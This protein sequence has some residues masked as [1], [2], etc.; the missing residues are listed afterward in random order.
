MVLRT[1][2]IIQVVQWETGRYYTRR[3]KRSAEQ[4]ILYIFCR[5]SL[6]YIIAVKN[7]SC[8]L[9]VV[10]VTRAAQRTN[11]T[12]MKGS[13]PLIDADGSTVASTRLKRLGEP[14]EEL[15]RI[16][17]R[18]RPT[19]ILDSDDAG[20]HDDVR[21]D[22][23]G[24]ADMHTEP[25]PQPLPTI[26]VPPQSSK[27]TGRHPRAL[28]EGRVVDTGSPDQG[29]FD[30]ESSSKRHAVLSN[31]LDQNWGD[32]IIPNNWPEENVVFT[33][34]MLWDK[35]DPG[36]L[37]LRQKLS[38]PKLKKT[39]AVLRITDPRH[40]CK[41]E[42]GVF[43][44]EAISQNVK[45]LNYAGR[46]R[47]MKKDSVGDGNRFLFKLAEQG[48]WVVDID[49]SIVGNESRFAGIFSITT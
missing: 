1:V 48:D 33:D 39:I 20:V 13:V 18:T 26:L 23:C 45:I 37:G 15:H 46:V 32:Q 21:D 8:T 40:P 49:A 6:G 14:D 10:I 28:F 17:K 7:H 24:T 4:V 44:T 35:V 25:S 12:R 31:V 41:G 11:S 22:L 43:S 42:W 27:A 34:L 29:E 3:G 5:T 36:A 38:R 2:S 19:A 47:V 30:V 16:A 9:S